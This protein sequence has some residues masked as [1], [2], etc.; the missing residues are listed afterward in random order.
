MLS[1]LCL[2]GVVLVLLTGVYNR[3][4]DDELTADLCL[5]ALLVELVSVLF[6]TRYLSSTDVLML[7]HLGHVR[8]PWGGLRLSCVLG[9]DE[10]S[11]FFFGILTAALL[12]CFFFLAEY[13]DYD[14]GAGM[15]A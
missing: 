1:A 12:V 15:I 10:Y 8:A 5:A 14:S 3:W 4:F 2:H 9:F 6:V 7:V 13:F 11:G